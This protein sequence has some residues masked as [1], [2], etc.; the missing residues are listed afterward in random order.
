M[1]TWDDVRRLALSLPE[2]AESTLYGKTAFKVRGKAFVWESPHEYGACTVRVD[3][4]ERPLLL[5]ANPDAYY[6]TQHYLGY[7][8]LLVNLDA[9]R[10]GELRERIEDAW[11]LAAP[12]KLRE[13]L[14]PD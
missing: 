2:T 6:V 11:L 10:I 5:E 13:Q 4:P 14:A 9:I 12:P 7:P 1:A 8:M 3:P